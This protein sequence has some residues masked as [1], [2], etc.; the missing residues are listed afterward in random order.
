MDLLETIIN[1]LEKTKT[2]PA[3]NTVNGIGTDLFGHY[4]PDFMGDLVFK[5]H[6]GSGKR[7]L[8]KMSEKRPSLES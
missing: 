5:I 6:L 2:S 1:S 4:S 8:D 7:R 3:L